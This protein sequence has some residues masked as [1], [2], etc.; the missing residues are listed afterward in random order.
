M[1]EK[2]HGQ[3]GAHGTSGDAAMAESLRAIARGNG[4]DGA[5][6]DVLE[7][8]A[9][10]LEELNESLRHMKARL[11][12]ASTLIGEL[13]QESERLRNGNKGV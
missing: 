4:L 6:S 1:I 13:A 9:T 8:A 10:R 11:Y 2:K 3:K 12:V 7:S 5:S